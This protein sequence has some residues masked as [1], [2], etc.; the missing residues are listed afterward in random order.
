MSINQSLDILRMLIDMNRIRTLQ[1]AS[2]IRS[3][4]VLHSPIT[5]QIRLQHMSHFNVTEHVVRSQHTRD[6]PAG[7]ERGRENELRLHV[8][9]YVPKDNLT[10]KPGDVTLIGA[11]ANGFPKELYEP[12][13]DDLHEKLRAQGRAIRGIWIADIASQGQSGIF[14][15]EILGPDGK[16]CFLSHHSNQP[17]LTKSLNSELVG[18]RPRPPPPNQH[19]SRRHSPSH[20]RSRAQR[21]GFAL[22][23]PLPPAPT[24]PSQSRPR[25]SDHPTRPEDPQNPRQTLHFTPGYLAFAESSSREFPKEQIL[26]GLGFTGSGEVDSVWFARFA[27]CAVS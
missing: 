5:Q 15:E 2:I 12:F 6:R 1:T 26:P 17:W 25:R 10:P 21:W 11:H 16:S 22:D 23:T 19:V 3:S 8:K 18:P 14:N 4:R 9:Q 20:H 27:Y 7:A 13:W 24:P